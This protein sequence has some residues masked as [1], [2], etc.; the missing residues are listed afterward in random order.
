[1]A[2]NDQI[3]EIGKRIRQRRRMLDIP[4]R[5]LADAVGVTFQ[6]ISKYETGT[7]EPSVL[8]LA[9]IAQA[10]EVPME[11]LLPAALGEAETPAAA[12][13]PPAAR[14]AG[15][16]HPPEP[17]RPRLSALVRPGRPPGPRI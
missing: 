3:A 6:Q 1:M 5:A 2:L 15:R 4:Q 9:R 12:A 16:P 17:K 7:N 13:P 14:R 8:V 10:L 11:Q